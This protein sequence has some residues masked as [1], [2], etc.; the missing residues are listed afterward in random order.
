MSFEVILPRKVEKEL[1]C[2]PDRVIKKIL[3]HLQSL[4]SEPF[5]LNSKKLQDREGYRLRIG[6]YRIL[7]EIDL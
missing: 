3:P 6:E 5:P 4:I 7:H 2:L 1:I